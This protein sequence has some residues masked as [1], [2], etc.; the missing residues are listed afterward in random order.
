[1]RLL[2]A[3]LAPRAKSA[4]RRPPPRGAAPEA[5]D[6]RP[7]L[8]AVRTQ[9]AAANEALAH[10]RHGADPAFAE[11]QPAA[12]EPPHEAAPARRAHAGDMEG[13]DVHE[14]DDAGLMQR[15]FSR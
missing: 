11:T 10:S 9:I 1:M 2:S 5:Q 13:L 14:T 8:D 4:S 15:F 12:M 3:L 7:Y 6:T